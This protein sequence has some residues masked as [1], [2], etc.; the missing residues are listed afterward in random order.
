M[1]IRYRLFGTSSILFGNDKVYIRGVIGDKLSYASASELPTSRFLTYFLPPRFQIGQTFEFLKEKD[2]T[3][4]LGSILYYALTGKLPFNQ[5][6][7]KN[8]RLY[9]GIIF[10]KNFDAQT[11]ELI[12]KAL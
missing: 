12:T 10:E 4:T 8:I 6:A 11:A 2:Y 9:E 7:S 3:F 5:M 1:D